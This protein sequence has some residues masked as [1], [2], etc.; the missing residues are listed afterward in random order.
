MNSTFK[1]G[2]NDR[3]FEYKVFLTSND[4]SAAPSVSSVTVV[5]V[6]NS[7]PQFDPSFGTNGV[8]ISQVSDSGDANWGKMKIQYAIEDPDATSGT[9][10]KDYITP[11]F[12]YTLDGGNNW[13]DVNLAN[14]TF[15][16]A[17]AG[18][19][20]ADR[21]S[22]GTLENKV[23]EGGFLT[24]VAYWNAKTQIPET[25]S[26]DVQIRVSI[27]D[28]E[29]ANSN[30]QAIGKTT[31]LD[32]KTPAV[33]AH[34]LLV[35]ATTAPATVTLSSTDD[36]T[37]KMNVNLTNTFPSAL[38]TAY[39]SSTTVPLLTNP[40]TV[41]AEFQ[42]IFGN[43]TPV[44]SA[45]TPE[46][47]TA[48][49]IQDTSNMLVTPH[50]YR[51]FTAWKIADPAT[52]V[53][54]HYNVYRSTSSGGTY[55]L[56]G[57]SDVRAA[58]YY[59]DSSA[60]YNQ[61]YFY[62]IATQDADGNISC[63]S[64]SADGK[65]DG[66][67]DEGEGGGGTL[68]DS[69][70][71]ISN[72]ASSHL[73]TTQA[74]ITWDTD[75]LSNSEVGYSTTSGN[76]GTAA[77]NN[78]YVNNDGSVGKHSVVLTGLAPDT[79]Y[80][81]ETI[82]SDASGNETTD[83]NGGPGYSFATDPGPAIS[84][85]LVNEVDNNE[86]K[87]AWKT[88]V[89]SDSKI[90]YSDQAD[91]SNPV[92]VEDSEALT[93]HELTLS[94]LD[95][96]KKYYFLVKSEDSENQI[97]TDDNG[98]AYYA[99]TTAL[100]ESDPVISAVTVPLVSQ[101]KAVITW[102]TDEPSTSQASYG[103]THILSSASAVNTILGESHSVIL[104]DLDPETD[105]FFKVKSIDINGNETEDAELSFTTLKDTEYQHD[106][107]TVIINVSDPPSVVTDT[108]A[109]ITWDTD[110]PAN[111]TVEYGTISGNY[112]EVPV[113][114]DSLDMHH[115]VAL[116]SLLYQTT[117][118][119]KVSS[120]DNLGNAVG[121]I[122]YSFTTLPKQ[123]D[124]TSGGGSETSAAPH[125]S[126]IKKSKI[127]AN[128]VTITWSTDKVTDGK[129]RYG[130]DDKYG[131]AAAEDITAS[132]VAEYDTSHEI[133]MTGLLAN[134]SY[135]FSVVSTDADG[136]IGTSGDN[137]FSTSAI[138]ALSGLSVTNITLN[139]AVVNWETA[140]PT[141]SVVDYGL[142]TTYG[143][144]ASNAASTN[145]HKLELA[146]LSPAQT[147]HLRVNGIN[148]KDAT[149]SIVSDDYVFATYAPP[150]LENYNVQ[151][152]TDN[153][154]KL[155]WKTNIP[156]DSLVQYVNKS[157]GESGTQGVPEPTADHELAVSNLKPGTEYELKITGTDVNK[158]SF[159][160]NPFTLTTAQDAVPPQV[161]QV[162]TESS[163]AGG[164]EDK[165]QSIIFWKTDEPS[166][167]Q[168]RF[169]E[170]IRAGDS[171][172]QESKED[173][174]LTTNHIIVLTNLKLGTVYH[175]MVVS[176]DASGNETVS[177]NFTLLTPQK[178]QSIIQLIIANF[179]QT[180]GWIRKVGD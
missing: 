2:N 82:S 86:V 50:E 43:T 91:L 96:E 172:S 5:Y 145:T 120:E 14:V 77:T 65:A 38:S 81:F 32:V 78:S 137:T 42:D 166:S 121:S 126:N 45:A 131:Q 142:T 124:D 76:F 20:I 133:I 97:A 100:D 104:T 107:L 66:I 116:S 92:T 148:K 153:F 163:L 13:L 98:G 139:S 105:Y 99:F 143:K 118:Y 31:A 70:P 94:G 59:G 112:N 114:D 35:D 23:L 159:T 22:D 10:T 1:G 58:N 49:M 85:V 44:Y 62:K 80:Y 7:P 4:L 176:K 170:G 179:E 17:P 162:K 89:A 57:T 180:F 138:A 79:T 83:D 37:L 74:T 164:K 155:I 117:Y 144:T 108:K 109:V 132:D 160:S 88:D 24:Y 84:G 63:Y 150:K 141:S 119:F 40:D 161:S 19:G 169:E 110:Q 115:S 46:T 140:N 125:I 87:V 27:T 39:A 171:F 28:N 130:L 6:V 127:T 29:L 47:P 157:S 30:A 168:V 156:T 55:D 52:P 61:H 154:A 75:E 93:V 25:Y 158:N 178:T 123:V 34:P 60:V 147:Y 53:F 149:A 175:F 54:A 102:T 51:L 135:H 12:E 122:E 26:N 11:T 36:S 72:V 128:S 21:N 177:D 173:G 18:G 64:S 111:S 136:N 68:P 69:P 90:I 152:V 103:K 146:N 106:P 15:G 134:T 95:A 101:D 33:G 9:V 151:E 16:A 113:V 73:D 48:V 3:W 165:V 167:S 41:Y 56:I 71:V 174:N 8:S 67:Q 129:I